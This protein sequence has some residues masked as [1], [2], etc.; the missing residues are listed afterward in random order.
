MGLTTKIL[1]AERPHQ[2]FNF[3][4]NY[5]RGI[6]ADKPPILIV[7]CGHSG[8]SVLLRILD[9]HPA[10]YGIPYESRA[11]LKSRTKIRLASWFWKKNTIAAGKH[12]WAEKTPSHIHA[13]RRILEEYPDARILLIVRDG[14]D[15]A[16]SLRKRTGD[17][18]GG[19]ARWMEDNRAG[20]AFWNHPQV[21]KLAYEELVGR[22]EEIMPKIC[23]F[24]DEPFDASMRD[25][26]QRKLS[27]FRAEDNAAPPDESDTHHNQHR[28]WQ[29]NQKLFDGSGKWRLEMSS[30]E[31]NLFKQKAGEML[32]EYGYETTTNW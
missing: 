12:R 5:F 8:T 21:F 25:F 29:I 19:I 6:R 15:V 4:I 18:A 27:L 1:H 30:E 20:E 32:I 16:I 22:F 24:L 31:K 17:F 9:M 28:N 13:I 11:F 3:L 2:T 10:I 26:H 14:R 23:A 7:G